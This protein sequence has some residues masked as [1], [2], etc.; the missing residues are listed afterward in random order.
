[1]VAPAI[2]AAEM[3]Q[4]EGVSATVVNA[5]FVK[6]LDE[7]TLERL[8]PPTRTCWRWRRGRW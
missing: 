7:G 4:R 5:R 2:A 1:M 8:F 6:P 3:L